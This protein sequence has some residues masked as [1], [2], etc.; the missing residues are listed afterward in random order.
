MSVIDE[1]KQ[2]TDIVEVISQYTKL[3][4]AGRTF[5]ALCPFHSE[6]NPSFFVYPDRQS[7]H[8]FGA[9]STGGDVFSFVMK[10]QDI[11]FGEALRL[12]ADRCGVTIPSIAEA[13]TK[14]ELK[15]RL[16]QANEAAAQYFH[17]LLL[18]SSAAEKARAYLA[19]RGLTP[20]TITDFQLGYSLNSWEALK[21]YLLDRSYAESEL[22]EAG[23]LAATEDGQT[24]DRWRQRLIF[25]IKDA[26]GRTTGFGARVL[27]DSLPKYINSP[28]TPIFDKS[29]TLYGL[30]LA[31]PAIRQQ[32][33]VVIVEG[34]M[35]VITAHQSGFNNVVASMGT[36]ITDK[37]VNAL[38]RLTRN[39]ALALDADS[40]GEEA[41]LRCVDFE[42]TPDRIGA[43]IK[44][45]ILPTG[46]DPDDVI[47]ENPP[48]WP[49]LVEAEA[50]PVMDYTFDMVTAKLDLTTARD[51]SLAADRLLPI[52]AQIKDVVRRAHYLQKLARL[53][54]VSER[55]L[56]AALKSGKAGPAKR[57]DR[58]RGDKEPAT[59]PSRHPLVSSPVEE[60]CLALLLQ[61]PEL[62]D[63]PDTPILLSGEYFENSE[64][65]EI[66]TAWRE[67]S[68]LAALRE[69]IDSAMWEHL[70]SLVNK[71]IPA[72]QIEQKYANCVLR[73]REKFLRNLEKQRE[74]ILTLEAEAGGTSAE[75]AKLQEQGIEISTEL[76]EVFTLKAKRGQELRR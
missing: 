7:W 36:A 74:A 9:C 72:S 56:E 22:L 28:Q 73:L 63:H 57:P 1:V 33:S 27:D 46:K 21:Q 39:L 44:V 14:K 30:N 11:E 69:R 19:S 54:K 6:K 29:A 16:Y 37:Q 4:K 64:N 34:Y 17:N 15:E 38:K 76:K 67:T 68:D 52:I 61:H 2:R 23:L 40:A 45:I 48:A 51:K 55:N 65:R 24:H 35:D 41:M 62:R 13:D 31:A 53:V 49:R 18:K 42:N 71:H 75:L 10:K 5:R 12:L 66:F 47:R 58:G 26:R 60:Y 59:K 20:K 32:D 70:D 8:C 43:E 25:P 50:I 3:T